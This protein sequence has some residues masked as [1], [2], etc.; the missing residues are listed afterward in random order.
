MTVRKL[1]ISEARHML[2]LH[3]RHEGS[4][5]SHLLYPMRNT[6]EARHEFEVQTVECVLRLA[7]WMGEP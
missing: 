1:L 6:V 2:S 5:K 4:L 3:D 7:M